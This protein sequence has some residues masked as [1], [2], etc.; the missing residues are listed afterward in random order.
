[1]GTAKPEKVC[2]RTGGVWHGAIEGARLFAN[3]IKLSE[4]QI[5][6][7]FIFLSHFTET[8]F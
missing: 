2:S 8:L 1:M 3:Y 5:L 7:I 4:V 6:L